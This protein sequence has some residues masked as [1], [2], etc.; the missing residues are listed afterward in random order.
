MID[1]HRGKQCIVRRFEG[2]YLMSAEQNKT[3]ATRFFEEMNNLRKLALASELFTEDAVY[4]GP[5][6]VQPSVAKGPAGVA[7]VIKIYQDAFSDAHWTV[8]DVVAGEGDSVTVRWIGSGTHD[9]L[10]GNIPPT[11]KKI[12]VKANSFLRLRNGKISEVHDVWDALA[13]MQ[14]LGLVPRPGLAS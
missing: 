3:V 1:V 8:L 12:R 2:E 4:E 11:G 13:L 10:L 14:Q 6:S 7:S 5:D 9:G